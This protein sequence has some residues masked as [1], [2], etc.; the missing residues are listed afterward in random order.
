MLKNRKGG[1]RTAA[2]LLSS[3]AVIAG[4]VLVGAGPAS[5]TV[6]T[7]SVTKLSTS[8]G[9][10]V[11]G[12]SVL[13]TGKGFLTWT[14]LPADVVFNG[15]AAVIAPIVLSDTQMAVI[16]PAK[17]AGTL[18]GN[19]IV[20]DTVGVGTPS[21]VAAANA[22]TYITPLALTAITVGTKLNSLGGTVL[23]I[24]S[25]GLGASKAAFTAL[26]ITAT[27]GSTA[28]A[29]TWLSNTTA[30]IAVPLGAASATKTKICLLS[31]G[32]YDATTSCDSLGAAYATVISKLSVTSGVTTGAA[33]LTAMTIT[34]KGFTGA[35]QVAF[36]AVNVASFVVVSDTKITCPIPA[37]AASP[38]G[39]VV[40]V[41]ITPLTAAYGTTATSYYSYTD[42]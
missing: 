17:G 33:G 38:V 30:T 6:A 26:K 7:T 4:T 40:Q 37:A 8:K 5:A 14:V 21:V 41:I 36:G 18:S 1:A 27:V 24:V 42:V 20:T 13:I 9:S 29:V 12:T 25:S 32:V 22:W 11:G 3:V 39:G 19:V 34:G 15:T 23:P 2:V 35:T 16:A 10:D 28:A 31:N